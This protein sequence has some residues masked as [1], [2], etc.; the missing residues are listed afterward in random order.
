MV[1]LPTIPLSQEA[2]DALDAVE[3]GLQTRDCNILIT[4]NTELYGTPFQRLRDRKTDMKK[5]VE[6]PTEPAPRGPGQPASTAGVGVFSRTTL[7]EA[8][9][10]PLYS[11]EIFTRPPAE[12]LNDPELQVLAIF[13]ELAHATGKLP[14]DTASPP[15]EFNSRI[16]EVCMGIPT[17]TLP[18]PNPGGTPTPPPP[19]PVAAPTPRSRDTRTQ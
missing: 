11:P 8:F 16:L 5:L 1:T 3:R 4:G 13:H 17:V 18:V 19:R 14:D 2:S 7:Y 12:P 9:Y 10:N 15:L 6:R